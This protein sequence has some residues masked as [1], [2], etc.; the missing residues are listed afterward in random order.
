[1]GQPDTATVVIVDDHRILAEAVASLLRG[2]NCDVTVAPSL[3]LEELTTLVRALGRAVVLLDL[4]LRDVV[5]I[6]FVGPLAEAGGIVIVLTADPDPRLQG[7]CLAHGA[8]AVLSKELAFADMVHAVHQ[9]WNDGPAMSRVTREELLAAGREA[10]REERRRLSRFETLTPREQVVLRHLVQGHSPKEIARHESVS[11]P[12][13]RTQ[14]RTLF[15]K[16][17]VGSQREAIALAHSAGWTSG[18]DTA[19]G[20]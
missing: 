6:P 11:M 1:V 3:E 12:T 8:V 4:H 7:S 13:V 16:L 15:E 17:G 20:E 19:K 14:L 10:E 5:S 2:H 9:A 18:H